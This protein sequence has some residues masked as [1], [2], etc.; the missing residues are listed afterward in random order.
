MTNLLEIENLRTYFEETGSI[1][2][3]VDG[4][5]L[6]ISEREVVGLVGESGSGKTTVANSLLRILPETGKIVAGRM[7]FKATNIRELS[8]KE[9]QSKIRGTEISMI[10]QDPQVSL[11]P[12][13]TVGEQITSVLKLHQHIGRKEARAKAID[14]FRKVE[15][16]DPKSR[17]RSY[18]HELSGGMIQRVTIAMA[19]SCQPSLIIADE[20]TTALDVTIQNQI[21]NEFKKL[22]SEIGVSVLWITH[23]LGV[24]KR[25]CDYV[26]VMYAGTLMEQGTVET[27]FEN[28]L[29]P[30]THGLLGSNPIHYR[31]KSK[32]PTIIGELCEIPLQGCKFYH[33]CPI[34]NEDCLQET[35]NLRE[36]NENHRI[37]CIRAEDA[38]ALLRS[39]NR[40]LQG[41]C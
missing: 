29:H 34:R 24:I 18:P 12:L 2:R 3:A 26:N 39:R 15:I 33:R 11:N 19:M 25:V 23:D 38:E 36:V 17:F 28:P 21:L 35:I 7:V 20:P 41:A 16:S 22:I 5:D 1:V 32:I 31:P 27:V 30:Y 10:F 13:F 8:E 37:R 14:L 40:D 4:V 9:M 6:S